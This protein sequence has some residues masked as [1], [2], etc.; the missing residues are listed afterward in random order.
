LLTKPNLVDG[1]L[2]KAMKRW[3]WLEFPLRENR[4]R[5]FEGVRK[6]KNITCFHGPGKRDQRITNIEISF[7]S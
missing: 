7:S 1:Q 5:V 2:P 3:D 4:G 6:K